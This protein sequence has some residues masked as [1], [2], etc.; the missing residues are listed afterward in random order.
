MKPKIKR[1]HESLMT[2]TDGEVACDAVDGLTKHARKGDEDAKASLAEY[3]I[4][5][6]L[7]HVRNF[8]CSS[9]AELVDDS[10]KELASQF[11]QG[12]SDDVIRYWCV[13]GYANILGR[14][15]YEKLTSIVRDES[16]S[17]DDRGQ[18]VKCLASCSG[19]PFDRQLPSDPGEWQE[20]DIRIDEIVAWSEAGYPKRTSHPSPV[21]HPAL[22]K[23]KSKLEKAASRLDKRLAK[24]RSERQ[25]PA[26]PTD[27][28]AVADADD[29]EEITSRWKL[30]SIYLDFLTRF[31]PI[32]VA[33]ERKRFWNGGLQLFGAGELIEAQEGY[34]HDPVKKKAIR[35]WSKGHLVVASH[36]GDPFVLDLS[37]SD[38]QDA[39]VLTAEHGT[40]KWDFDKEAESFEKFLESLAK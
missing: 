34:A 5:G 12:L 20:N 24:Q 32:K 29:L 10:D 9:L 2:A 28:L 14:E 40:G 25:D 6:Q 35:G 31:S 26:D 22:D 8:A 39:P 23:P 13:L 36:G 15:A 33:L 19:Q 1:L 11:E 3:M 7:D 4:D 30:P 27:W 17:A 21:R 37:S 16:I 38:G 18:A